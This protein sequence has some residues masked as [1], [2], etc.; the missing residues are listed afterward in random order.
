ME[1]PAFVFSPNE[2]VRVEKLPEADFAEWD[3]FIQR[4]KW[5]LV[6]HLSGWKRAIEET[7]GHIRGQILVLRSPDSGA[8]VAGIPVYEVKS[9]LV[10]HRTVSIP[11]AT[12]C[13]PLVS[14][15][16]QL[17]AF[18]THLSE[19]SGTRGPVRISAWRAAKALNLSDTTVHNGFL[20]HF[21]VLDR[22]FETLVRGFSKTAVRQM[23]L[24]AQR[25]GIEVESQRGQA[26]LSSFYDLYC[27]TRHRLGLPAMPFRFF[28]S[29]YRHLGSETV[30]LFHA[31]KGEQ[32]LASALALKWKDMVAVECTGEKP[33]ARKLGVNQLLWWEAIRRASEAG[34]TLFSFGRTHQSNRGLLEFK[35]R[36]GTQEEFLPTFAQ[37][38]PAGEGTHPPTER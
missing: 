8:I 17:E 4:H 13:D 12:L 25:S 24:R 2:L 30:L 34:C 14:S 33:H 1:R 36:W 23:V 20:H 16:H 32:I 18:V 5:G 3:E 26:G 37:P 9:R 10:G 28:D 11:F 27:L 38:V 31:R 6:C 15:R 29:L 21:L 35:R 7:F 19:P 22:P